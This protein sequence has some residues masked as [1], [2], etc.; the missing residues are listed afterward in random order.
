MRKNLCVQIFQIQTVSVLR[1]ELDSTLPLRYRTFAIHNAL[2]YPLSNAL[3]NI[4][5]TALLNKLLT[6]LSLQQYKSLF[7]NGMVVTAIA[8]NLPTFSG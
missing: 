1:K 3:G 4:F 6:A 5:Q 7:V 8:T 2:R